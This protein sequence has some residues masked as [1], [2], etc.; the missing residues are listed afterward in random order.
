MRE[1]ERTNT[2]LKN[3]VNNSKQQ[4]LKN[5]FATV[6]RL[7]RGKAVTLDS[8]VTLKHTSYLVQTGHCGLMV[9]SADSEISGSHRSGFQPRPLHMSESQVLLTEIQVVF[10]PRTPILLTVSS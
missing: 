3:S 4:Q 7:Y 5:R 2:K 10:I 6:D 1:K 8:V 9:K